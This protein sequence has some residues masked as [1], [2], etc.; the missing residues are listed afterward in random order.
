MGS[1]GEVNEERLV[2]H[3]RLL[4]A[5]P[6]DRLVGHVLHQVIA[7]FRRLLDFDRG[8]PLVERRIPLVRLAA[9]EAVEVLEAAA[10]GRPGVERSRRAGLPHRHLMAFAELRRGVAVQLQRLGD[11]RAGV[12]QDRAVA[13]RAAGD[14]RDAAHADRVMVAPGQ[15][16]LARRRTERGR[17]KTVYFSPPAASFSAFGV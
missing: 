17:V 8:R 15:Q 6:A 3:E 10:A 1:G 11:R 7:L 14:L 5:D 4:L 9:D 12:R 16:R 13:W 2:G